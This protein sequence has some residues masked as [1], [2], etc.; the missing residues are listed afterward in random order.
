MLEAISLSSMEPTTLLA[1]ES[2]ETS[3]YK[4]AT[5]QQTLYLSGSGMDLGQQLY[6]KIDEGHDYFEV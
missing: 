3:M 6:C 5:W 4:N 2:A 1:F